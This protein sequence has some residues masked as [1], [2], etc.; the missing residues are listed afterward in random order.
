MAFIPQK[1]KHWYSTWW[2]V[3]I[4]VASVLIAAAILAFGLLI[5]SYW[6]EVKSGNTE[7]F[8]QKFYQQAQ[9]TEDPE[10]TALRVVLETT[11]DPFLGYIN[12]PNVIVE[13]IDHKCPICK[14]QDTVMR[15]IESKYYYKLKIIVRDFPMESVHEGTTQYAAIAS[16]AHEQGGYSLVSNLFFSNQDTLP[17]ELT[18]DEIA[19]MSD[20]FG[21]DKTK[22]RECLDSGR[23]RTEVMKDYSD[24]VEAGLTKGTPTYFVNGYK[25]EGAVPFATWEEL[26]QKMGLAN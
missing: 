20:S 26:F 13:F 21:L 18:D 5:F 1:T 24:A 11:D 7:Y 12:A 2:G 9:K 22:M 23:G 17:T 3:T 6:R 8:R 19:N 16:C 10:I 15:Q 4:L 14:A 25:L